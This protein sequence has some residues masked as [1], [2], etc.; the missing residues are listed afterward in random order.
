MA[1]KL[2]GARKAKKKELETAANIVENDAFQEQGKKVVL[3]HPYF[4]L[5]CVCAIILVVVVGI[6]ISSAVKSSSDAKAL[7]YA[8]ATAIIENR[9]AAVDTATAEKAI[10]AFD[11]VI[12]NQAGSINA[13]ASIVYT[14]RI[15]KDF[16]N[17]CDK[18]VEFFKQAKTNGKLG[19]DLRFT[20]YEGEAFCHFDKSEFEKAAEIWKEWLNQKSSL[21]KD[22]AL[23]YIAM[24][25]E[26]SGKQEEAAVYYNR[27][28]DEYPNSF[29][30]AKIA[31]KIV[32]KA[33]N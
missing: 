24:S 27:I 5:G 33:Q 28:K 19:D 29:L 9:E 23:Y 8:E 21:Y 15:Y 25:Y 17:N 22:Y 32:Q 13:A 26:K 2:R 7:E 10:A 16:M 6:L 14:G 31:G 20:A 11:K 1:L 30:T 4:I 18:A 12:K 3:E